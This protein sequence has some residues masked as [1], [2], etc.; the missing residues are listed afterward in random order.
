MNGLEFARIGSDDLVFGLDRK[1]S[2]RGDFHLNEI[3]ELARGLVRV[4]NA[5]SVDQRNPLYARHPEAW[6][7]SRVRDRKSVV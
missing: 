2:T 4:R 5:D 1:R 7:E 3:S 6:L